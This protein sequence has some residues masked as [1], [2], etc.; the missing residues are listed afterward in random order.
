MEI[1]ARLK[2]L[3]YGFSVLLVGFRFRVV[4]KSG[5]F[6]LFSNLR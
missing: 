1:W 4:S 5:L 2:F 3:I 6:G